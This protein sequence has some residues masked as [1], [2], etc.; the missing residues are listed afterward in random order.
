MS[1]YFFL[2]ENNHPRIAI[3]SLPLCPVTSTSQFMSAQQGCIVQ[4]EAWMLSKKFT[5]TTFLGLWKIRP[6]AL[7]SQCDMIGLLAI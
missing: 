2:N 6:V 4:F 3:E 7:R 5:L 1:F